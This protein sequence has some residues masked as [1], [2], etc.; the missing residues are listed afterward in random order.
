VNKSR[1]IEQIAELHKLKKVDGITALNDY[2]NREGIR[3][4]IELGATCSRRRC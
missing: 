4:V 3:V 2:T 1:L